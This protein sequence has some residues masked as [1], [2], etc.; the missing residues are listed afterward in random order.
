MQMWL[1]A[2]QML[3]KVPDIVPLTASG[4]GEGLDTESRTNFR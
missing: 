4:R 1:L 2:F 3:L